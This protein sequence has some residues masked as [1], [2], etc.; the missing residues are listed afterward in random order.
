VFE[1]EFKLLTVRNGSVQYKLLKYPRKENQTD[2]EVDEEIMKEHEKI[3]AMLKKHEIL[4]NNEI[5]AFR[6]DFKN[7]SK[8]H[9]TNITTR[10]TKSL[11]EHVDH[12]IVTAIENRKQAATSSTT[13]ATSDQD[14]DEVSTGD[15]GSTVDAGETT[16]ARTSRRSRVASVAMLPATAAV[17]AFNS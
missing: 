8:C 1:V 2:A 14:G 12:K 9:F 15:E 5:C 13:A 16:P 3:R 4:T 10:Q 6:N 17:S 7:L 11:K